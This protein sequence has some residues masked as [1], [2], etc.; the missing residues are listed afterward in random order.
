MLVESSKVAVLRLDLD[1]GVMDVL[2]RL[3]DSTASFKCV[4]FGESECAV[5][6][7]DGEGRLM[8]WHA[9]EEGALEG[10]RPHP[11]L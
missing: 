1:N 4:A 7:G 8:V 10:F 2:F 6:C 9:G 3:S 5:L 11:R